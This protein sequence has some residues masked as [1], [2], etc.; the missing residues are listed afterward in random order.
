MSRQLRVSSL[1]AKRFCSKK[2]SQ[3]GS[4]SVAFK[5]VMGLFD[6]LEEENHHCAMNNLYNSA[7]FCKAAVNHEKKVLCRGVARKGMR[8]IL[9]TVQQEEVK[10]REGQL[11]ARGTTKAAVLQGDPDC[12]NLVAS[13]VYDTKPVH[14]VLKQDRRGYQVG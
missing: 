5:S 3:E 11:A 9:P 1:H 6:T 10:S 14:Y 4:V 2:V 13:S 12:V 7:T 8:G